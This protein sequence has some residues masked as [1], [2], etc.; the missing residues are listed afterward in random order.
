MTIYG[1]CGIP[2]TNYYYNC[3]EQRIYENPSH[4]NN[5]EEIINHDEDEDSC[6]V[7]A[8]AIG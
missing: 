1:M 7:A 6:C 8:L 4:D 2:L 3:A 5:N